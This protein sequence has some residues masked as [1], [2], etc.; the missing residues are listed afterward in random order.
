[1]SETP[2]DPET[3]E[4]TRREIHGLAREIAELSKSD[5]PPE[6][7]FRHFLDRTITAMAAVGG[8]VWTRTAGGGLQLLYQVN[9]RTTELTE[10]GED[11]A[12]HDRLLAQVLAKGEPAVVPPYS[13]GGQHEVGNPTR[14]LL[15][16]VPLI[17]EGTIE[18]IIEI[19][20]RPG[21]ASDVQRGYI[22]FISQMCELAAGWMKTRRLR[23]ITQQHSLWQQVD[24][25]SQTIHES[26]DRRETAYAIA[27]DGQRIL[28]CDRVSV[29]TRVGR[30]F[31]LEAFSGQDTFD[32][33]S[34]M[35]TLLQ[36][37]V[38]RVVASGEG[39]LYT[40]GTADLP[41]QIVTALEDY[42][43]H[44][45]SKTILILPLRRPRSAQ[46]TAN[47]AQQDDREH[48]GEMIGAMVCEQIDDST[49]SPELQAR[50]ELL[51]SHAARALAN[52]HDYNSLFLMPVW[53]AIG[54]SRVIVAARNLPKTIS[55]AAVA[56]LLLLAA[57][58]VRIDFAPEGKGELQPLKRRDI[59]ASVAG[60]VTEVHAEHGD[61]V[62]AGDPL[63]T[64]RNTD[65]MVQLENIAGQRQS[66]LERLL[67]LQRQLLE[68][69]IATAE[70]RTRVAGE[71][72]QLKRQ[73]ESFDAQL[74]LLQAK[75]QELVVT[76]PIAGQV[77]TWDTKK[78]LMN[79]PVNPGQVLL[80]VA[81]PRGGWELIVHMPEDNMG[82]IQTAIDKLGP[83]LAASYVLATDPGRKLQGKVVRVHQL[84]E[85]HPTDGQTV[86]IDV[87]IN[88]NDLVDPRPGATATAQIHCGRKSIAF[89]WLHDVYEFLM[90]KVFF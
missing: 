12:R 25:F 27:N 2:V 65:L 5:I 47:D 10:G 28:G 88:E 15:L 37:L 22:K 60:V 51:A 53:R 9:F 11:Q 32:A 40:G 86:K 54:H 69:T 44:A 48:Q 18:G 56:L 62:A 26:L 45:H 6:E 73:K 43:D 3:I 87:D 90:T 41:P 36:T 85:L 42:V 29:A 81:N 31:R 20:Q 34:S 35:V 63:V 7:Y 46:P 74:K 64:L 76:S 52:C 66:T 67:D 4:Q 83:E 80:T 61:Q 58:L 68:N 82:Y 59:F 70:E 19:F 78:L 13:G 57:L 33:R 17:A 89:V 50:A 71:L 1:M 49:P 38:R 79:R 84:S 14:F 55:I 24:T 75:Q 21:G 77:I 72:L 8:A 23:Q 39:L 30:E 16:L